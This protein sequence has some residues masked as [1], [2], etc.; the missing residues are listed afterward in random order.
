MNH[1]KNHISEGF[2]I[3][4]NALI[5]DIS[6]KPCAKYIYAFLASM[7]DSWTFLTP[8]LCEMLNLNPKT[9]TTHR[10]LL[11]KKHWLYVERPKP[12]NGVFKPK[13]YHVLGEPDPKFPLK[14]ANN[15][16]LADGDSP[17]TEKSTTVKVRDG[18]TGQYNKKKAQEEKE[19]QEK[20]SFLD[21]DSENFNP[22]PR[23]N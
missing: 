19:I 18:E 23:M 13:V 5:R 4:P 12:K 20:K 10:D 1:I 16:I 15:H 22:N 11:I 8:T 2:T 6:I 9:F 21:S 3:I 17:L 7:S 14:I